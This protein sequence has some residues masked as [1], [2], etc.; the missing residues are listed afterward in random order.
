M[1]WVLIVWLASN[2]QINDQELP[3]QFKSASECGRAG[4]SMAKDPQL[5][6][7]QCAWSS[8]TKSD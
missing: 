3:L 2:G 8:V 7:Y 5:V 6:A 4:A 1:K